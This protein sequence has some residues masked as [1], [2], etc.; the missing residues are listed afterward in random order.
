VLQFLGLKP[1]LA[2]VLGR[3][4]RQT[5]KQLNVSLLET[6]L[7]VE[8]EPVIKILVNL[9]I[10][11]PRDLNYCPPACVCLL[12]GLLEDFICFSKISFRHVL[13]L[14]IVCQSLLLFDEFLQ[15]SLTQSVEVWRNRSFLE[16]Q[17]I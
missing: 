4:E 12:L 2:M 3:N 13:R 15:V 7:V 9:I 1:D 6:I 16:L 8:L 10:R 5:E 17:S 11:L 14:E